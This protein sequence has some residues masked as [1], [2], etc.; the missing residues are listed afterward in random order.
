MTSTSVTF[1]LNSYF[2][3]RMKQIRI[4]LF[5]YIISLFV[6]FILSILT[7]F[8]LN[9]LF[10]CVRIEN[11][12]I[13]TSVSGFGQALLVIGEINQLLPHIVIPIAMYLIPLRKLGR[14]NKSFHLNEKLIDS[15]DG[16]SD[17]DE[18]DFGEDLV[19]DKVTSLLSSRM[20]DDSSPRQ[21][22]RGKK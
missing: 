21:K 18:L 22:R 6:R 2:Q 1:G 17:E 4:V 15:N 9:K 16:L 3:E 8:F 13:I 5:A 20:S 11:V 10:K 7:I 14:S 12:S 19:Q